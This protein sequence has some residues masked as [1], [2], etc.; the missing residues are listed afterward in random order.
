MKN[1]EKRTIIY[2]YQYIKEYR[3]LRKYNKVFYNYIW[4]YSTYWKNKDKS[5]SFIYKHRKIY[6]IIQNNSI[7][8]KLEDNMLNCENTNKNQ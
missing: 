8:G 5:T 2:E 1:R 4:T 7:S 3:T 6:R